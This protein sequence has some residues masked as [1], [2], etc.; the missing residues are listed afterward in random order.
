MNGLSRHVLAPFACLVLVSLLAAG[1]GHAHG[2]SHDLARGE[3][4]WDLCA[5]C[6]G[7]EGG[8][9][10]QFLAPAI[11]G[12]SEWYVL[13]Q[14]QKFRAGLRGTHFDDVGGMRMRPM[15][16]TLAS[17]E[18]VEAVAAYVA[19]LPPTAPPPELTGGDPARGEQLYA[20]CLACHGAN[21]EGVEQQ[22]GG[23]LVQVSDWYLLE[24]L[25]KFKLGIRGG[26]LQD[27]FAVMMR[28]MAIA[29][30]DE[31]AMK[32]VIAYIGTLGR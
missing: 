10:R 11:A 13:S 26:N 6:H 15:S 3:Q 17:E 9:N 29:L 31:Q 5:S 18:D 28:P 32:D 24:Q 19:S 22:K 23:P 2:S 16:M 14:L 30:V 27:P 1:S 25:R 21:G 12:M 20:T 8:G 4:L 7:L